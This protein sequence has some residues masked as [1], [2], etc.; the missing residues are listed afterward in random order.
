LAK[1]G[2]IM[3]S[4]ETRLRLRIRQDAASHCPEELD[5]RVEECFQTHAH[6]AAERDGELLAVYIGVNRL[7]KLVN[8]AVSAERMNYHEVE[9]LIFHALGGDEG[10][11]K[12]A[13]LMDM[14]HALISEQRFYKNAATKLSERVDAQRHRL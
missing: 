9:T 5:D 8:E 14:V 4:I 3:S 7:V 11:P 13:T 2:V 6:S 1:D 10:V 12:G